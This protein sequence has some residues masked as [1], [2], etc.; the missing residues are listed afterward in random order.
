MSGG[1]GSGA[2]VACEWIVEAT[3]VVGCWLPTYLGMYGEYHKA[4]C[5]TCF[6]F[7]YLFLLLYRDLACPRCMPLIFSTE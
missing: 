2:H 6:G 7:S 3:D 5:R 4:L 1:G